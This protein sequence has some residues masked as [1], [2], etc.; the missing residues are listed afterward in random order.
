M[1]NSRLMNN[2]TASFKEETGYADKYGH[3]LK[4][5]SEKRERIIA[6][7]FDE[8]IVKGYGEASTNNIVQEAGIS[9]GLLFRYFG[10]KEGL[11][12]FLMIESSSSLTRSVFPELDFTKGDVFDIIKQIT[13]VKLEICLNYPRESNFLISAWAQNN[14]PT[15]VIECRESL[16]GV[17]YDY[18]DIVIA[19]IDK[20]LLRGDIDINVVAEIITWVC[21]KYTD[22]VLAS[23]MLTTDYNDW[24]II[25]DELDIYLDA[26]RLGLYK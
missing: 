15:A 24:N 16:T 6:A 1:D 19:M 8:F 12:N 21:E 20:T 13:R 2:M 9:K 17:S 7:A 11:Y 22:K 3:F 14:L 5:D 4:L 10:N 25:A 26:L 23:G 18:L